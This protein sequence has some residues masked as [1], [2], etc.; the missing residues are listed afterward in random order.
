MKKKVLVIGSGGREHALVWKLSQSHR[1]GKIYAVP[2][3]GGMREMAETI[4]IDVGDL[5]QIAVFAKEKGIDLTIVGPEAPLVSGIVN[6]FNENGLRIFGPTK[7]A[8]Q[9]E[10]SKV[11]TK[12]LLKEAGIPTADFQVC[13]NSNE[14]KAFIKDKGAPLVIKADGLCAGKGV[15]VALSEEEALAAVDSIMIDRKFGASGS[16]ILIEELLTGEEASIIAFVDGSDFLLLPSSQDHKRVGD[17]DTGANTGGMGAY[18]PA[19]VITG[20]LLKEIEETVIAPTIAAMGRKG[21]LFN[22]VLYCGLM[23]TRRGPQ[24]L[25]YNVRFGDPEVQAILPRLTGDLMEYLEATVDGTLAQQTVTV[26]QRDCVCVVLASG[27]Y[28][29]NYEK[30]KVITGLEKIRNREDVIVFHAGTRQGT[31]T[32][33]TNGGRV[34][35]VVALGDGIEQAID[36]AYAAIRDIRFEGM[37]YRSDIGFRALQRNN[38]KP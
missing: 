23:I 18:S 30:G 38:L 1:V 21:M 17:N 16:Q 20:E 26:D 31:D 36:T 25:E 35:N 13:E 4:P 5:E 9:L 33:L 15:I 2:G 7:E 19:P 28:P 6:L 14:A 27:G 3:N 12:R 29:E 22:G 10:G 11:F 37:Y 8:A 32:L 24:V 34:L